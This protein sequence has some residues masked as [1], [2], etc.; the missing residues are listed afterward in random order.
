ML[1]TQRVCV[2]PDCTI[3]DRGKPALAASLSEETLA[4]CGARTRQH[5]AHQLITHTASATN[6]FLHHR[7]WA[8]FALADVPQLEVAAASA[9]AGAA[10]VTAAVTVRRAA[11]PTASRSA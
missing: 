8:L 4:L 7:L 11:C 3:G 9:I 10:V 2:N 1:S 5:L 6:L